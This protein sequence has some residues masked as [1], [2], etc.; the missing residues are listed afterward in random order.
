MN[1]EEIC[2]PK[3]VLPDSEQ[4]FWCELDDKVDVKTPQMD[5][6]LS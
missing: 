3:R 6:T 5:V 4:V 2:P 1:I